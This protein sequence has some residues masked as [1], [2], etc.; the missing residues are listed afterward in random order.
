MHN[1][2]VHNKSLT[3][4]HLIGTLVVLLVAVAVVGAVV[5]LWVDPPT[6]I[7][8]GAIV[9]TLIFALAVSGLGVASLCF[10]PVGVRWCFQVFAGILALLGAFGFVNGI[11]AASGYNPWT[12]Q[13]TELPLGELRSIAVD[14]HGH[15]YCGLEFYGRVQVYDRDGHFLRGWFIDGHG[16]PFRMRMNARDELEVLSV[17]S[18]S[19]L[20]YGNDGVKVSEKPLGT[21]DYV[22]LYEEFD[23]LRD[24][25]YRGPQ[26]EVYAIHP[27][28]RPPLLFNPFGHRGGIRPS[29]VRVDAPNESVTIITPWIK[30]F[31]MG[32]EPAISFLFGGIIVLA[33][34]RLRQRSNQDT[35]KN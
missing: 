3:I 27:G 35:V 13:S 17:G 29:V 22:A 32:P 9:V 14:S 10:R 1:Q 8:P 15:I 5:L 30:W 7:F 2:A 19:L 20:V 12:S 6:G 4:G 33:L 16:K 11:F 31:W 21:D 24:E 25:Q 18:R 23:K 26:G 34:S 28:P